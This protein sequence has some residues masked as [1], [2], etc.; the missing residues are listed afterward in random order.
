MKKTRWQLSATFIVDRVK[1][2]RKRHE[3]AIYIG[4]VILMR[5][6][7][8]IHY[9]HVCIILNWVVWMTNNEHYYLGRIQTKDD[10]QLISFIIQ[11]T[12]PFLFL[13]HW[14]KLGWP[15]NVSEIML[16]EITK[17]L[18]IAHS[19]HVAQGRWNPKLPLTAIQLQ[20]SIS[21]YKIH[22]RANAF[23]NFF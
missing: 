9:L 15:S 1:N 14:I 6:E 5:Q 4:L 13:D 11:D 21:I 18:E 17:W 22:A 23:R 20:I 3:C 2:V 7:M 10:D 12:A 19:C 16:H 8:A